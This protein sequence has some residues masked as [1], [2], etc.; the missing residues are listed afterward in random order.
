M[1]A[2]KTADEDV[3]AILRRSTRDDNGLT[4]VAQ[5]DRNEYQKVNKFLEMAGAKW[6]KKAGRHLFTGSA[7]VDIEALLETGKVTDKKQ[8]YQAFHTPTEIARNIIH[9]A[10]VTRGDNCLEPSAGI[11]AIANIIRDLKANVLCVELNPASAESLTVL[12][13]DVVN[14]DFLTCTLSQLHGP[15]DRIVMNPPFT[16]NQA[17]QHVIHAYSMLADGGT[18]VSILP[19][20]Q[21]TG[22]KLRED[23]D[24]L[25]TVCGEYM[26]DLPEGTFKESG[27][28]VRCQV[29]RLTK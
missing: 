26:E 20:S 18:L 22:K 27:T 3:L 17:F 12:G 5:L 24:N 7:K 14:Q 10:G 16:K 23:W 25:I 19:N 29:L 6:N 21:P 1:S 2:T 28:N 13:H 9:L 8:L 15:F 4:L 11:G